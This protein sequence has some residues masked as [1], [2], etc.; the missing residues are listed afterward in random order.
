VAPVIAPALPGEGRWSRTGRIVRGAPPVLVTTYRPDPA[1]PRTVA[2]V[3]WID[4]TR[5]RLALYPG[6][7]EPPSSLPRGPM[8]VPPAARRRLVATF[9]SGFTYRDGRGGF[10]ANGHAYTPLSRNLATLVGYRDGSIDVVSWQAGP[11]PRSDIVFARQNLPLLVSDAR[12]S[13]A[14]RSGRDWG[15]TLGNATRVWRSGIG[16]DARGNLIYVA[17]DYQTADSLA[18]LLIHAGAVRA[19]QLD[20]NSEWPSFNTYA[21]P[22]AGDP[23]RFVPNAQQSAT[24]YL[25][26]DDRDFFA[27]FA[28]ASVRG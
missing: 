5:T 13:R 10:F 20:I 7:Y 28:R 18:A 9:N 21:R 19:M 22:Y 27:V 23:T 3:A 8:E 1:Y 16:V 14:L 25:V 12:P 2:Y 26:P 24:R 17:A 15:A 6:R 4:A 11:V